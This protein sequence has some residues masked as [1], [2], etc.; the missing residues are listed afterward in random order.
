M[1]PDLVR[2]HGVLP[3]ELTDRTE[4]IRASDPLNKALADGDVLVLELLLA[5]AGRVNAVTSVATNKDAPERVM[6]LA[7]ACMLG[8]LESTRWLL[9]ANADINYRS[10]VTRTTP[11]NFACLG[12]HIKV[13][14][15]L[16][17]ANANLDAINKCGETALHAALRMSSQSV[18]ADGKAH[19]ECVAALISAGAN[20]NLADRDMGISPLFVAS[21]EGQVGLV[22]SLLAA[23]AD[24]D[25]ANASGYTALHIACSCP[26]GRMYGLPTAACI[27]ALLA[28]G[29]DYKI[30]NKEGMTALDM[31]KSPE[32]GAHDCARLI[33]G[34]QPHP[35]HTQPRPPVLPTNTSLSVRQMRFW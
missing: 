20:V 30:K 5:R 25:Q 18:L 26:S 3:S 11:L 19:D 31:A 28:A 4:E 7:L 22:T 13:V 23:Q 17:E 9:G 16:I 21:A 2:W 15:A 29:A 8:N 32:A 10:S 35:G 1:R 12:G 24:I 27:A 33:E 6:P 14:R 34:A